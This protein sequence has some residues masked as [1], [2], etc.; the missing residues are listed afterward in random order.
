MFRHHTSRRGTH[1]RP[2]KRTTPLPVD[3]IDVLLDSLHN[4]NMTLSLCSLVSRT[5]LLRSRPRMFSHDI[6]I[7]RT[8]M[9]RLLVLMKSPHCT[10]R[11]YL[12]RMTIDSTRDNEL[13]LESF[14][15]LVA[16]KGVS[17]RHLTVPNFPSL[18]TSSTTLSMP[19]IVP[20]LS[21]HIN[22]SPTSG[23]AETMRFIHLF[24]NS[25]ENLAIRGSFV[26]HT[27]P[28][29]TG[30]ASRYQALP[31]LR[32]LDLDG[33]QSLYL[34]LDC[35]ESKV[36]DESD[37]GRCINIFISCSCP[38]VENLFLDY[39]WASPVSGIDLSELYRLHAFKINWTGRSPGDVFRAIDIIRTARTASL[40]TINVSNYD[41][42]CS[43]KMLEASA[44]AW[45]CLDDLLAT[46]KSSGFPLLRSVKISPSR[47]FAFFPQCRRRGYLSDTSV[48]AS[49][50]LHRKFSWDRHISGY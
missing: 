45:S 15:T 10:L 35:R 48:T 21:L 34:G 27:L 16:T 29:C 50:L 25:L 44:S 23:V 3:I 22:V 11:P 31:R 19:Y 32:N 49:Y 47:L 17:L 40:T 28:T 41:F 7:N 39:G 8:K 13:W 12:Q 26:A 20:L 1:S 6:V 9:A 30:L 14:F 43:Q 42:G 38:N 18:R 24:S 36:Y 5:W 46:R 2:K 4:D 37:F 33:V